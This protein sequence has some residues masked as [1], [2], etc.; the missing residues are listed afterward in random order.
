MRNRFVELYSCGY[1][2]GVRSRKRKSETDPPII[3]IFSSSHYFL[4]SNGEVSLTSEN[5]IRI[6]LRVVLNSVPRGRRLSWWIGPW[7][8][9]NTCSAPTDGQTSLISFGL[10]ISPRRSSLVPSRWIKTTGGLKQ[11]RLT[12]R[13]GGRDRWWKKIDSR[14]ERKEARRV[15]GRNRRRRRCGTRRKRQ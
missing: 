11:V 15:R 7:A 8:R 10:I 4:R 9:R 12:R 14:N 3:Y 2:L 6:V 5:P 13:R 1:S